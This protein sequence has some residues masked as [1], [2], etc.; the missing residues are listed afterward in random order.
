MTS[1]TKYLKVTEVAEYLRLSKG[2]VYLKL[3][4]GLFPNETVVRIGKSYRFD[5][6]KLRN[7]I[8]GN[9]HSAIENGE[10]ESK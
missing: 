9:G 7:W 3:K 8:K 1:E 10:P 6:E 5:F 4:N 2:N